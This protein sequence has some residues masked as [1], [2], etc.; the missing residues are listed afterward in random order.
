MGEREIRNFTVELEARGEDDAGKLRV[1]GYAAT[2][3]QEYDI[4]GGAERGGFAEVMAPGSWK[5]TVTMGADIR[6]LENHAGIPYARTKAGTLRLTSDDVGLLVDAELDPRQ[7]RARDLWAAIERGDV[8]Q[9]S[10]A[11]EV[12]RQ[13]W[14]E[15]RSRRTIL[16]VKG[17]D[18]SAVTYPANE[19]TMV[20][21]GRNDDQPTAEVRS[22]MSLRHA[23]AL[24]SAL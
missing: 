4:Y 17:Y 6:F 12:V 13:S 23:Q 21:A 3:G 14:S 22:G 20:L 16:E 2:Y 5:R 9:M 19:R 8:D 15:D 24:A 10:V 7:Q 1:V 18:V 11:F